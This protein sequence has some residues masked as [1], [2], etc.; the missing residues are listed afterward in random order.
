MTCAHYHYEL[1]YRETLTYFVHLNWKIGELQ[2]CFIYILTYLVYIYIFC[3]VVS[4]SI[5]NILRIMSE[6]GY[7]NVSSIF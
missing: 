6:S 3:V 1:Q 2:P 7:Q 4:L 5:F